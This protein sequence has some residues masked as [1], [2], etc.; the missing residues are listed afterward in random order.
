M[1]VSA[2]SAAQNVIC[3]GGAL[4]IEW[5]NVVYFEPEKREQSKFKDLRRRVFVQVFQTHSPQIKRRR[6]SGLESG[7]PFLSS[8]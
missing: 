6:V 2:L 7:M 8:T 5:G 4:R 1:V 3:V